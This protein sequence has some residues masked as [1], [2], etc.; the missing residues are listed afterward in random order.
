MW[1]ARCRIRP[2][3]Q[4]QGI[5]VESSRES[6]HGCQGWARVL[7]VFEFADRVLGHIA[8]PLELFLCPLQLE[9]PGP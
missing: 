1:A 7:V 4:Q 5:D 8:T 3:L 6:H 2:E 9:P